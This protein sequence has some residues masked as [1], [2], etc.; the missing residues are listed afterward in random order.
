VSIALSPPDA[1]LLPPVPLRRPWRRPWRLDRLLLGMTA[2]GLL[3][4]ATI[5]LLVWLPL[6]R[7]STE[8]QLSGR[9]SVLTVAFMEMPSEADPEA[10][11]AEVH[12]D[13]ADVDPQLPTPMEP[14]PV[15]VHR[16]ETPPP[17]TELEMAMLE[18]LARIPLVRDTPQRTTADQPRVAVQPS[19][20][21]PRRTAARPPAS[22]AVP[23][24]VGSVE[25]TSARPLDNP[26]PEYPIEA[27]RR[28]LDGRVTL[29]VTVSP[30]GNVSDLS[31]A[32]GSGYRAFDEAAL[33]AV[34]DWQFE[35]ARRF[36][37]PVASTV[38]LPIRFMPR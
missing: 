9:Q 31:V 2:S 24:L 37:R 36:G 17:E 15:P 33:D 8:T 20:P 5:V 29:R 34:E 30:T 18:P 26:L 12:V 21:V 6:V 3:H 16:A 38:L 11:T 28:A 1:L 25:R 10:V 22:I 7:L 32:Q 35:P 4:V 19:L 14:C 13:F 23:A 27:L